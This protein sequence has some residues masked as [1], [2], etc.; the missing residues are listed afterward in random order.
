MIV[1]DASA[2]IELVL[3]LPDA[4]QVSAQIAD[5][6]V[7][8]HAPQLLPVEVLHV[9]RRRVAAASTTAAKAL[10]ALGL[11]EDL[12]LDYRDHLFPSRGESGRFTTTSPRMMRRTSPSPKPWTAR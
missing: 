3:N 8:L 2:A 6:E 1:L 7:A 9:L 12:D 5:P 4:A 10:D 11:L